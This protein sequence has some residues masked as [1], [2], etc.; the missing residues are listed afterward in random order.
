MGHKS[1]DFQA[2]NRSDAPGDSPHAVHRPRGDVAEYLAGALAVLALVRDARRLGPLLS[3][4]EVVPVAGRCRRLS[5]PAA[6]EAR[7]SR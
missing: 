7:R 1:P 6:G 4:D 3:E 2:D 5:S